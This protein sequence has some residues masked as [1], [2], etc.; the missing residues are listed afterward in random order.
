MSPR[1]RNPGNKDLA[2]IPNL[3]RKIDKRTGRENWQYKDPR[4]G[5]FWGLGSDEETAKDRA[6]QLNSAIY[7]QM[8]AKTDAIMAQP[9]TSTGIKFSAWI[10]EYIAMADKALESG[11]IKPNTHRTRVYICNILVEAFYGSNLRSITVKDVAQHLKT[12]RDR[13]KE[14]MA[15]SV[16]STLIDIFAEA[17]QAGECDS[18][19]A[20]LTKTG[21]AIVQRSR[22]TF[23]E[24]KKIYD[25]AES[26]QPWVQNAMLLAILTGQRLEDISLARFKKSADW[27]AAFIAYRQRKPHP[28]KPYAFVEGDHLHVPQQKTGTLLRIPL[29]L[30]LEVIGL[31]IGDV[32]TR[33][34]KRALSKYLIHHTKAGFNQSIGDSVHLNTVSKG[35]KKARIKSGL[36]WEG[37]TPPTFHEQR[38]LAE[39]LYRDQGVDTKTL[40]GHKSQKMTDV[41]HDVRGAEW[42]DVLVK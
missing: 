29:E 37:K 18:N 40:L 32:V 12:F 42:L 19:P 30:R 8:I 31:S 36:E 25:A 22:L 33:C 6:K 15:Q 41:Y 28:I 21:S 4:N 14:R 38:S 16:R 17:I 20:A 9:V 5:K 2:R 34:R 3:Y 10:T 35:F 7:A 11:K 39:R 27:E 24:W 23:E 26:L 1:N 13:G